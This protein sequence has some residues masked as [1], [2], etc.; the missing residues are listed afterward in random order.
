MVGAVNTR[1]E[2][3][4]ENESLFRRI[5]ER[6]EELSQGLDELSI[7]CECADAGCVE[8]IGGV[9]TGEYEAVRA[10]ADRFFV[11]RGHERRDV[12]AVVDERPL[13]LIVSKQGPAGDVARAEDPRSE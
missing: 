6:V 5:N 3:A 12:E 7:V 13:Y 8:R 4:A 2:R 11:V 10:H 1:A 9:P